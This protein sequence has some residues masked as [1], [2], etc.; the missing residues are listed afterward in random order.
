MKFEGLATVIPAEADNNPDAY[1]CIGKDNPV[2]R[3]GSKGYIE[4]LQEMADALNIWAR[5]VQ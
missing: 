5:K 2:I 1:L 3:V 4:D